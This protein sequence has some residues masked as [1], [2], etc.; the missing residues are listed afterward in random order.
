MRKLLA[1]TF[2]VGLAATTV[3]SATQSPRAELVASC[4]KEALSG[5]AMALRM[6][7]SLRNTIESH[8]KKMSAVCAIFASGNANTTGALSQCLHEASAGLLH[9]QRGRNMDRAHASR[10]RELCQAL[11]QSKP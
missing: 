11:G 2:L 4:Q 6:E 3:A 7:P 10:Q 1:A 5:H 8:R 9:T